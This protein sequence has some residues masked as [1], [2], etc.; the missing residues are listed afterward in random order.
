MMTPWVFVNIFPHL[1]TANRAVIV[2]FPWDYI[3]LLA[4]G[5][6]VCFSLREINSRYFRVEAQ[7]YLFWESF[8]QAEIKDGSGYGI[9]ML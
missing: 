2:F 4:R 1:F 8:D 9:Q 3:A 5:R 7:F 6:A